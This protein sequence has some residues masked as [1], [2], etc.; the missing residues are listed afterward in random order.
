MSAD[1]EQLVPV[2]VPALSAVLLNAEDKK[3]GPLTRDEV[4]R[5]SISG[6]RDSAWSRNCN[7]SGGKRQSVRSELEMLVCWVRLL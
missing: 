7:W 1:G 6:H 4:I 2:F 3:G 5:I